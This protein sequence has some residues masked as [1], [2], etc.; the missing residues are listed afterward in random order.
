MTPLELLYYLGYAV[1]RGYGTK[2]QKRL[3]ARVISIGNITLGGTGKTPATIA[4]IHEA[5]QRGFMPCVL[6]RG[7]GGKAKGPCLV[8]RG[9]GPLMNAYDAGDEAFL[10][11]EKLKGI[12]VVKGQNRYEA[13]MFAL[14]NLRVQTAHT[15]PEWIFILDDGFQHWGLFRDTDILLV[16][17]MNPFGN[18]KLLPL[19]YL[20]EPVSEMSRADIIVITNTP[21]LYPSPLRGE[22]KGGGERTSSSEIM[23]LM[24]EIKQDNPTAPVF[25]SEHRPA[26]FTTVAGD[27]H[28]L[29]WA[30]GR[31]VYAFCGIGN[32]QSFSK[33]LASTGAAIKGLKTFRDHYR[34]S[35]DDMKTIAA[36]AEKAGAAWI[37]TTEK[38][39]MR[40]RGF[41][42]PENLVALA[43]EFSA[44]KKFYDRVFQVFH[45]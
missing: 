24:K 44:E 22:G 31:E 42:L 32:P 27:S 14:R 20:R 4:L 13:G 36:D 43:I 28:P 45:A 7:Y 16:D 6:T 25:F 33:T 38:D 11:A 3:P 34:F 29:E 19:G 21:P 5:K 37:V 30:K 1:H 18:R 12:P 35:P 17:G 10:M 23:G 40:L 8:S 15:Q 26:G 39:I 41:D 9:E 2:K